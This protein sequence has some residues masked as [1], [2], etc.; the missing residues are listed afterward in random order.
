VTKDEEKLQKFLDCTDSKKA[1]T[2]LESLDDWMLAGL[3][4]WQEVNKTQKN[5]IT[6]KLSKD[7]AEMFLKYWKN[8]QIPS[9]KLYKKLAPFKKYNVQ[10]TLYLSK[11]EAEEINEGVRELSW[12]E[13]GY[14]TGS[15]IQVVKRNHYCRASYISE[16]FP[17]IKNKICKEMIRGDLRLSVELLCPNNP[18][19]KRRGEE[20]ENMVTYHY[21]ADCA[22]EHIK[23][24]KY[25]Y[26]LIKKWW[27][28]A[29]ESEK[30]VEE[31]QIKEHKDKEAEKTK[32]TEAKKAEKKKVKDLGPLIY[33]ADKIVESEW[34]GA[35]GNE[36]IMKKM[37]VSMKKGTVSNDILE[38]VLWMY[39]FHED[40]T[41]RAA[42]KKAFMELAPDDAKQVV[43]KNW[44]ATFRKSEK[45]GPTLGKLAK[46]LSR[47]S[48][49]LVNLLIKVLKSPE[50][51]PIWELGLSK[52]G[53]YILYYPTLNALGISGDTRAVEPL[54]E[55]VIE[56]IAEKYPDT[57]IVNRAIQTLG[58]FGEVSIEPLV[59][60]LIN[61]S[62]SS[63]LDT[64]SKTLK[65]LKW[66]PETEGQRAAYLLA[67]EDWESL[68]ECGES[69][70]E[71]LI[72]VMVDTGR[73]DDQ[74]EAAEALGKIGD[75]RAVEPIINVEHF[76]RNESHCEALANIGDE[77]AVEP[78]IKAF[79]DP[80]NSQW[81]E[82]L[83]DEWY[84]GVMNAL[85]KF[86]ESAITPLG[87]VV[88]QTKWAAKTLQKIASK[89]LKGDEK[90]NVLRFLESDDPAMVRMGA[91]LL[92]G[93]ME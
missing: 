69:A 10:K 76:W 67:V 38:E 88:G 50:S 54:K 77:R 22:Q 58:K 15:Q 27:P 92:K 26:T 49:N 16:S 82:W 83:V 33:L 56:E 42:A 40:S 43:K 25:R 85:V 20:Y 28:K 11:K 91:S 41:A 75:A 68:V 61:A 60:V 86:G 63:I 31:A 29:L 53:D 5:W 18:W 12:T 2:I 84:E 24:R 47:T 59:E 89:N 57:N 36:A 70:I 35:T 52:G 44:K 62:E 39:M 72:R 30:K 17:E 14:F 48:V 55:Y 8:V 79:N 19:Y 51:N 45:L 37:A 78:L 87:E 73:L 93:A 21:C 6:K 71:P 65:K 34:G 1:R 81:E 4:I 46:S 9:D 32:K 80:D 7:P 66:E 23:T 74:D 13:R 64:V 90:K 3:V